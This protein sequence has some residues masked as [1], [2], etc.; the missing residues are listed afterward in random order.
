MGPLQV[1]IIVFC[2]ALTGWLI[3]G[4][5]LQ[6]LFGGSSKNGAL[7]SRL[8]D[9]A[10]KLFQHEFESSTIIDEKI[11]DPALLQKLKPEIEKHVDFFLNE[12][13]AGIFPLLY[14][15]MGEKT[16][17]QFKTA[18]MIEIDLLF[19]VIIKS[20][21]SSLKKELRLDTMIA[22]R[23]NAIPVKTIKQAFLRNAKKEIFFFRLACTFIGLV[24][25]LLAILL[26]ILTR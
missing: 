24:M 1:I 22:G 11:S 10:G 7:K 15:F 21:L 6:F 19:P 5:T 20:Y 18:F 13:L 4:F 2:S 26:M 8:A 14:K 3:A 9:N 17:S 12:K 23:I 25:G 16:L